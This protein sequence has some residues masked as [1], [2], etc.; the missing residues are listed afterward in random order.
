MGQYHET[1]KQLIEDTKLKTKNCD[2]IRH[3]VAEHIR[4]EHDVFWS[5]FTELRRKLTLFEHELI[6]V[7]RTK[8]DTDEAREAILDHLT[9]AEDDLL[10]IKKNIK[11]LINEEKINLE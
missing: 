7:T 4:A 5:L 11:A 6:E 9:A 1:I 3:V 8:F 2:E 10:V